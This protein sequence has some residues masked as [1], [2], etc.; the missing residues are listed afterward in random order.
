MWSY[1]EQSRQATMGLDSFN[2][3]LLIGFASAVLLTA[4][5]LSLSYKTISD[6]QG[7]NDW[8]V[9]TQSV[10]STIDRIQ[11]AIS[12]AENNHD[13][14]LLTADRSKLDLYSQAA[15]TVPLKL[16]SLKLLV[17]DNPSQIKKIDSMVRYSSIALAEFSVFPTDQSLHVLTQ[18]DKHY[19]S[20]AG[21]RAFSQCAE[22]SNRIV[23]AEKKLLAS[24]TALSDQRAGSAFRLLF[25]IGIVTFAV[26]AM[27][28]GYIRRIFSK[29][30]ELRKQLRLSETKFSKIFR[31]SGVGMALVSLSGEWLEINPYLLKMLG[32]TQEEM[33]SKTFQEIT[34]PDDLGNDLAQVWRLLKG[35][36]DTYKIEK[37]YFHRSGQIVWTLLTVSLIY[38]EDGSP[39]FFV[40]QI[41]DISQTKQLINQLQIK[42][43]ALSATSEDLKNKI[44]QLEE[45]NRI[46]AHNLRGPASSIQMIT[47]MLKETSS[48]EERVELIGYIDESSKSLNSTL[49]ELVEVLEES[50][51]PTVPF[52]E[53]NLTEMV[54]KIRQMLQGDILNAKAT[55]QTNFETP[56]AYYP[57]IYLENLFYNMIS[58]SLKYKKKD[59]PA[60]I[61][62]SSIKGENSTSL[63]FEDEGLGI[64]LARHAGDIFKLNQVFH[65][66]YDSKGIGLYIT[67]KQLERNGSQITV[68]SEPEKGSTFTI[69]L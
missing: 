37:R 17:S 52:E 8:V 33:L 21:R 13:L 34:H 31:D 19:Q 12:D 5:A 15:K 38:N 9:H 36:D 2:K 3:K 23:A 20:S 60:M 57:K 35:Y 26:L 59:E 63:I 67:K 56:T 10:M 64:D 14:Y 62:I 30:R 54:E 11:D 44:T 69:A 7:A 46:V 1:K 28:F 40:S 61:R 25:I 41:E 29:K 48:E 55:I 50:L 53:C 43:D 39:R 4:G 27:L 49:K 58:N 6:L 42:N 18:A 45:F 24:R 65:K 16:D 66:G 47:G 68:E 32:Y 51:K 22:I